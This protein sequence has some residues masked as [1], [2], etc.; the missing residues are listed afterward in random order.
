MTKSNNQTDKNTNIGQSASVRLDKWLWA[1]RFYK[2]RALAKAAIEG[3][4]I[5][6]EGNKPKPGKSVII[7]DA[8]KLRQGFDEKT[9]KVVALSDSRQSATIAQQ[10]YKETSESIKER[11]KIAIL[12]KMS[13]PSTQGKPNK[14]QRRQ[15]HRFMRQDEINETQAASD[16]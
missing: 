2:T 3:G 10:L 14:K 16:E 9:V 13:A 4:K 11:E 12:R 8:V 5:R 6:Y 1:C 15:I 7:G